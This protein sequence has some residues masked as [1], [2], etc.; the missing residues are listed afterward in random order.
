ML[1]VPWSEAFAFGVGEE[2]ARQQRYKYPDKTMRTSRFVPHH[3]NNARFISA[4]ITV[5]TAKGVTVYGLDSPRRD[6]S[7]CH[8]GWRSKTVMGGNCRPRHMPHAV[9]E[10][11]QLQ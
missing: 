7:S 2:F 1:L 4:N 8:I 11:R 10:R 5:H 3:A 9:P 6:V